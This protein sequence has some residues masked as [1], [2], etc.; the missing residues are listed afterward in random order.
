MLFKKKTPVYD[1]PQPH[2]PYDRAKSDWDQRIGHPVVQSSNWRYACFGSLAVALLAMGGWIQQ[3]QRSVVDA[4]VTRVC[5]GRPFPPELIAMSYQ[6]NDT[7]IVFAIEQWV[8]WVRSKPAD[9]IV[10]RDNWDRAYKYL[11]RRSE[12]KLTDYARRYSPLVKIGEDTRTVDMETVFRRSDGSFEARWVERRFINGVLARTDH[13][14]AN[15][16]VER[17]KP[18]SEMTLMKNPLGIY[19]PD[20]NWNLDRSSD[21]AS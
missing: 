17:I 9:E 7:E 5:D 14:T 12:P 3:A 10:I 4:Y 19:F 21:R 18:E 13:Y 1:A 20:F 11:T 8:R 2:S 16:Q 6:P 15:F